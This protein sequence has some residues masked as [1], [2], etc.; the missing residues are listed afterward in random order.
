M[1]VSDGSLVLLII[2]LLLIGICGALFSGCKASGTIETL[3]F[4]LDAISAG[5]PTIA[6]LTGVP[7]DITNLVVTY[8][9][10]TNEAL[11]QAS[12]ILAGPGTDAQKAA[13]VAAAFAVIVAPDLPGQYATLVQLIATVAGDVAKFLA[14]LPATGPSTSTTPAASR[15]TKLSDHDRQSLAAARVKA[16]AN[17]A[18]LARLKA[19]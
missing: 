19:H 6:K 16:V 1:K 4:A 2:V 11:S 18:A 12:V 17:R 13:Q 5:F 8:L 10:Q 9:D 14:T 7:A 3:Q 15:V